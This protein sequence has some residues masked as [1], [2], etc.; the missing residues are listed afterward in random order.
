MRYTNQGLNS[1][2]SKIKDTP[3]LG[4][5]LVQIKFFITG[6]KK[7]V[8]FK[9]SAQYWNERYQVG[10]NSGAGS[11]GRL[12]RYKAGFLNDFVKEHKIQTIVEYGCGDGNQLSLAD[13]SYYVGFDVSPLAVKM[14]NVKFGLDKTKNYFFHETSEEIQFEGNFDLAISLDVIYHLVEDYVFDGY[15]QRLFNA[16]NKYVIIY[17]YNFEK[18]YEFKH[19]RGRE[20]LKWVER[21][22]KD[23]K[24]VNVFENPF[25]YEENNPNETSQSD[26]FVFKK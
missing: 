21:N 24:L 18:T 10:G 2:L 26:F 6:R 22:A 8:E 7:T 17:A 15:M 25:P 20:F 23:W 11:Y 19:E 1:I 9:N 13:Y 3:V 12:A 4:S 14:C 5:I 16:S